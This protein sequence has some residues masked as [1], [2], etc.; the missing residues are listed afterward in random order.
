VEFVFK[1]KF[2]LLT[3][4]PDDVYLRI[5]NPEELHIYK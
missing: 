1:T 3:E 5:Y 2:V 4:F